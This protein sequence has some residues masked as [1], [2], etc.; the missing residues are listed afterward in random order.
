MPTRRRAPFRV[1]AGAAILLLAFGL[2]VPAVLAA[3]RGVDIRDFA[4]SPRT[5]EIRVGDTIRWTNRD[6]VAHTATAR[7]GSFDTGLLADGESGSVRFTTAGTYRYVCTP[8]P[9]MTGTVVVRAAGTVAPPNTSTEAIAP[10]AGAGSGTADALLALVAG[11][12]GL[13]FLLP[14]RLLRRRRSSP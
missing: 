8:H 10:S 7:N 5:I 9:D 14:E 4:F 6:S 12:A 3:T 1:L 11:I 2:A 13:A